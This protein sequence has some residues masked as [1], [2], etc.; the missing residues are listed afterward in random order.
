MVRRASWLSFVLLA[1]AL[2][3]PTRARAAGELRWRTFDA[4]LR[5]ARATGRPVLVDVFTDWCRY[6]KLMDRDVYSRA[7]VRDYL[8]ARFV[9]VRFN[10]EGAQAAS[11]EG[12]AYSGP[13]ARTA[14]PGDRVPDHD[15][16]ARRWQPSRERAR[17]HPA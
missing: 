13:T 5:E 7:D 17:L 14:F 6:C 3:E 2:L 4:G 15:L 1:L 10:A 8:A 16:P 11:Y 12:K 9:P